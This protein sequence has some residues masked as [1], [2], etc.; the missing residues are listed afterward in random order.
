MTS[1][2]NFLGIPVIGEI[3]E[4]D[5]RAKQRPIEDLAPLMQAVLDDPTIIEFGWTQYTPY[6]NDGDPCVFG[7]SG[8]IWVRTTADE[9]VDSTYGLE[10]GRYGGH[11]SLGGIERTWNEER[12]TY[13][14]GRYAGSDEARYLRCMA[15]N[16]AIEGGEFLDVLLD[17]FGDHAEITVRKEGINV[18]FYSHD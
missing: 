10:V 12:R 5:K 14:M 2:N 6:F 9:E 4:G 7:V 11:P 18:G 1:T 3:S 8:E 15:L 17:A 16:A 13:L